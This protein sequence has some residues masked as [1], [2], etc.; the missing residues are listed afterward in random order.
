MSIL[1]HIRSLANKLRR[2][3]S[4][5]A[6]IEFAYSLPLLLGL[7]C[8]GLELTNLA[9]ANLKISQAANAL[10]DNLSRVG[11]E[12]A[13]ALTQLREADINDGFI[14]IIRQTNAINLT[15]NGRVILSSLERN[16][17]GGQWIHWQRCL[18]AKN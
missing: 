18:G 8:Y 1:A 16:S 11:L 9:N 3:T 5:L 7:S 12:S 17:S 2:D 14:G 4:G 13:L 6:L 10:S 15:Q